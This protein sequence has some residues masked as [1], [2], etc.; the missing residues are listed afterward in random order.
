MM[1]QP[2]KIGFY[3]A[4]SLVV[5]NMVGT[6]VFTSLGFQL[7]HIH[8]A[9]SILLLWIVGGII[10]Y[11]GA[12]VYGELGTALPRSG[13]EY[14]YLSRLMHPAVGFLS[15][16]VSS[17]V[18]FAAPVGLSSIALGSYV[19]K[20]FPQL[21]VTA[22]AL[23][24]VIGITILHATNLRSGSSFQKIF[25]SLKVLVILV[26][27][28]AGLLHHPAHEMNIAPQ[29]FSWQEIC[30]SYFAVAL[31]YVSYAYS[32]WNAASYIV[33]E[34]KDPKRNLPK[35]LL[36]GTGVVTLIYV[37]LNY[38][39]L[40]SA[41]ASELTGVL[42][43]GHVS[44]MHI[45]GDAIGRLMSV[46]I[47]L[48]LVSS[49]SAMIMAGPRIIKTMAEDLSISLLSKTNRNNVPYAAVITQSILTVLFVVLCPFESLLTFTGFSLSVFTFLTVLSLFILRYKNI[50]ADSYKTWGYP[51]TPAIFLLFNGY[52]LYN[53]LA[54]RPMESLYGLSNVAIGL[55]V[56]LAGHYYAK[57]KLQT[58]S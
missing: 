55:V 2:Y 36:V 56:W 33:G 38:V 5:A 12:L 37:L 52:I 44:A 53:A 45:F 22:C 17:T 31:I 24:V 54:E 34:M 58:T 23:V 41:P 27:I 11:C 47:A 9:F 6:G 16:W 50:K 35:A 42:E 3:T 51:V 32:G 10:S 29:S 4:V 15:G 25:T 26:F 49:I 19:N 8:S 43:V 21:S 20:I 1:K 28:A 13:G 39:F 48:L 40:Y 14:V 30:S 46:A 57:K 7:I 18:G